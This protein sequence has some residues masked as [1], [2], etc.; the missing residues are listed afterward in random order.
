MRAITVNEKF[1]E[2]T[3]PVADMGIGGFELFDVFIGIKEEATNKWITFLKDTLEKRVI[4]GQ[5]SAWEGGHDWKEH[6][7]FV[8]RVVNT[9][10]RNGLDNEVAVEDNN[11]K[12]Y[13]ILSASKIYIIE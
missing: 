5:M 7:L 1:N 2:K 6:T 12:I 3:D 8:K 9:A 4:K 10:E 11:G 13:S